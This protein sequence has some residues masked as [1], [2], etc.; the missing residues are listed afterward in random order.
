MEYLLI[1][2]AIGFM[3]DRYVFPILDMLL[4]TLQYKITNKCTAIQIDTNL[5]SL[6][7]EEIINS[8]NELTPAIGFVAGNS[9]D[10]YEDYDDDEE[11]ENRN[12]IGFRA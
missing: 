8:R 5:L 6:E 3:V 4:E 2:L 9:R 10:E 12:R 11:D 7:Y 1:G